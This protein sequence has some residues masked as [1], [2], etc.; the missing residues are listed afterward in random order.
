FTGGHFYTNLWIPDFRKLVLN[1]IAWTAKLEIPTEGVE[2]SLENFTP[3]PSQKIKAQP[4]RQAKT[5]G[6]ATNAPTA[7][8][9]IRPANP[10]KDSGKVAKEEAWKDNRWNQTDVGQFLSSILPTP[11]GTVLKGL[12]IRVGENDE[13]ALCYD[14]ASAGFR[15]AWTGK[16]LQFD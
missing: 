11:N 9:K 8:K 16:F 4:I 5:S 1:A 10:E 14:T 12:S 6:S 3:P 7:E 13:G 2:S 15:A